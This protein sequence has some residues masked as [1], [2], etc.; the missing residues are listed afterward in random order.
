MPDT[1]IFIIVNTIK[2]E[3]E[4]PPQPID[5][6]IDA[7][8]TFI[9]TQNNSSVKLTKTGSPTVN[10]LQYRINSSDPWSNYEIN[11]EIPLNENE[12]VQFQNTENT[13]DDIRHLSGSS[14]Y[15]ESSHTVS[16][17]HHSPCSIMLD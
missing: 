4:I 14:N 6:F 16:L 15:G 13:S 2:E 3:H 1:D 11:T 9:A 17:W 5:E 7:P 10:G 8:L 12:Y